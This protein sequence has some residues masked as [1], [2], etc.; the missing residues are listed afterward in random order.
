MKSVLHTSASLALL[1]GVGFAALS[2]TPL[3]PAAT[4]NLMDDDSVTKEAKRDNLRKL[5]KV[6]TLDVEEQPVEDIIRFLVDVTGADLEPIYLDRNSASVSGIDPETPIT[7]RVTNI[8]AITVLERI[9][10]R[11]NIIEEPGDDYTW[12]FTDS[13]S[14]EFG[15]KSE[16]NRHQRVELYDIADLLFVVPNFDDAPQFNLQSAIQSASSGGGGGSGPFTQG[17]PKDDQ[18]D[19]KERAEALINLL[20]TT[21]EPDQWANAGGDGASITVYRTSLVITAADYVHRQIDGY[22]FWPSRLTQVRYSDKQRE[23]RIKGDPK[24]RDS[25]KP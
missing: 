10:E 7:I 12:Q 18:P 11:A 1:A 24:Y 3:T 23:V 6:I 20:E 4:A 9:L 2:V 15:P 19:P 13:G 14:I 25:A 22:S 8:P 16:L 17:G 5:S 21:V